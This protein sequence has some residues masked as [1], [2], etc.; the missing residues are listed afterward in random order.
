MSELQIKVEQIG[1]SASQGSARDHK[2]VIDRPVEKEGSNQG[3]MGGE[4]FLTGVGGCFMSNLLAA[5][6]ARES[7]ASNVVLNISSRVGGSPVKFT[8]I[9]VRVSAEQVGQEE[10]E[11]L[12][13]IAERGCIVVN[14][15]KD[16]IPVTFQVT[17]LT[18]EAVQ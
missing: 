9:T 8:D 17:A 6:R 12:V 10:L 7:K 13:V 18:A 1:V 14:S 11:K 5:I 16:A 4:L 3:P 15:I 2:V